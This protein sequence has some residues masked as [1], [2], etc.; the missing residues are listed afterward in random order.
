MLLPIALRAYVQ[1][2]FQTA[3]LP[4]LAVVLGLAVGITVTV[5]AS[6]V[7]ALKATRVSPIDALAPA[8]IPAPDSRFPWIRLVLGTVLT[9]LGAAVTVVGANAGDMTLTLPGAF[10]AFCGC[11]LYTSDAADDTR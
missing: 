11:L 7:P 4:V 9:A 3:P 2:N 6:F 10:M 5:A 8:D 1:A